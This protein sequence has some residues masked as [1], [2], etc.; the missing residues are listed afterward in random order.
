MKLWIWA[1]RNIF[2][3]MLTA[4]WSGPKKIPGLLPEHYVSVIDKS[5]RR[6]FAADNYGEGLI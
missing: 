2:I 4:L 5:D 1:M 3:R 6:K